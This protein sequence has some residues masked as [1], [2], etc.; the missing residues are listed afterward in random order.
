MKISKYFA[1]VAMAVGSIIAIS[2]NASAAETEQNPTRTLIEMALEEVEDTLPMDLGDGMTTTRM[3]VSYDK[4][5]IECTCPNDIVDHMS[6]VSD[7]SMK[8][9]LLT[10]VASDESTKLLLDLCVEADMGFAMVYTNPSGTNS[11]TL[12]YSTSDLAS[13]IK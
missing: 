12:S 1:M 13:I 7:P 3:Y 5:I 11:A 6:T 8:N 9:L 2:T 4:L 10:S